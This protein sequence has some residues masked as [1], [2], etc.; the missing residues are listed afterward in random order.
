MN[1]AIWPHRSLRQENPLP[2]PLGACP[3]PGQGAAEFAEVSHLVGEAGRRDEVEEGAGKDKIDDLAFFVWAHT[4]LT[5]A[6]KV[7]NSYV[8]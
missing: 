3:T 2:E 7:V 4:A 1:A 8:P 5:P 6:Q